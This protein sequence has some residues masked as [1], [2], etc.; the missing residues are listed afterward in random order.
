MSVKSPEFSVTRALFD[1]AIDNS[2]SHRILH[3]EL[4]KP[5]IRWEDSWWT[6]ST[7]F[8][9]HMHSWAKLYEVVPI[10]KWDENVYV[11][12]SFDEHWIVER[13]R[14]GIFWRGVRVQIEGDE[15]CEQYVLGNAIR[16]NRAPNP[17]PSYQGSSER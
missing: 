16:W 13:S 12:G 6:V 5:P 1:K 10:D 2:F 15:S 3:Q 17:K 14:T 9:T 4:I 11:F 7:A 8:L